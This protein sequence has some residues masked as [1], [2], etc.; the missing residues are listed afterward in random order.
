MP[1][2]L[3][4]ALRRAIDRTL[5]YAAGR[6]ELKDRT[7]PAV[8]IQ[9]RNLWM[10]Y[11]S[12]VEHGVALPSIWDTGFG[13]FSEYDED[14]VILFLLSVS[15]GSRSFVDIGAGNGVH[16]SNCANLAFNFGYHG[17]FIDAHEGRIAQGESIY[18]A[19]GD[20][21]RYPPKFVTAF[22]KAET[23]NDLIS[24]AGFGGDVD[25]LSID[26]DGNDYWIWN[27]ISA[28]SARLVVIETRVECGLKDVVAPY[29]ENYTFR[30]SNPG[31][32]M[33]AS[34]VAMTRLAARLGYRLVGA[35]RLGFNLIYLRNDV[36]PN[37]IAGIDTREA[38]WHPRNRSFVQP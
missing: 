23:V 18:A 11:R 15:N 35:N 5:D 12:M 28:V 2:P 32:P 24:A 25:V 20:T 21:R 6:Q 33:G 16:A 22:V 9:L 8:K 7:S 3:R 27:A 29:E 19:H 4:R 13:V 34:P 17:L 26:I 31:G 36:A 14:G 1:K 38:L 10:T 37:L 30:K